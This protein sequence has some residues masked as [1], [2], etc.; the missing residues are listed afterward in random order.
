MRSHAEQE[1]PRSQHTSSITIIL[2]EEDLISSQRADRARIVTSVRL[3]SC[4]RV[5]SVPC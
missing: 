5:S 2:S 3:L 4:F 1:H